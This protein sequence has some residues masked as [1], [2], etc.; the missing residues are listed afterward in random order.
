[1]ILFQYP[2]L[3]GFYTFEKG[4][5]QKLKD[6]GIV[7]VRP[8]NW[9]V[10]VHVDEEESSVHN[11]NVEKNRNELEQKMESLIWKINMFFVC[12]VCV[13]VGC[14]FMYAVMK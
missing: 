7:I 13:V 5:F 9:E 3:C 2:K 10:V 14:V 1:M 6:V 12:V 11:P 4:Y 8:A